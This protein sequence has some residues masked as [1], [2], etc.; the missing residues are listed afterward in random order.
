MPTPAPINRAV[1]GD[2]HPAPAPDTPPAPPD[3]GSGDGAPA[4]P[5]QG[6]NGGEKVYSQADIDKL[7]GERDKAVQERDQQFGRAK[8]AETK[9]KERGISMDDEPPASPPADAPQAKPADP[10]S[11]ARSVTALKDLDPREIDEAEFISKAMGVAPEEAIKSDRFQTW[12]AGKRAKDLADGKVPKPGSSATPSYIKSPEE[13]GKM[14][15][16]EHQRYEADVIAKS[17]AQGQGV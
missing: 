14:T 16:E 1:A 11:L 13:V 8:K 4:S 3:G 10:F 2:T 15:K 7:A 6:G 5:P 17:K 12:V 9:L